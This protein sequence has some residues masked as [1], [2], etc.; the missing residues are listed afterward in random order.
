MMCD[1]YQ[2]IAAEKREAKAEKDEAE[3]YNKLKLELVRF[4]SSKLKSILEK[5]NCACRAPIGD[6]F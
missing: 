4:C 1:T 6:L 3:K 2:G 5:A